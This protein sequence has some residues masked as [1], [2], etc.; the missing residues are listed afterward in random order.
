MNTEKIPKRLQEPILK[1][2]CC[3]DFFQNYRNVRM[4]ILRMEKR[5]KFLIKCVDYNLI[6]NFLRLRIPYYHNGEEDGGLEEL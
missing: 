1:R 2:I 4:K 3:Y 5:A 6:L